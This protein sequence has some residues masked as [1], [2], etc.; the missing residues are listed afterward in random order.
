MKKNDCMTSVIW[1]GLGLFITLYALRFKLGTASEPGSG[2]MPF[3]SG[4]VICFCSVITFLISVVNASG[5]TKKVWE[6]IRI[7]KLL[8]VFIVLLSYGLLM[9]KIGFILCTFGM[10]LLLVRFVDPQSWFT[11]FLTA[12]VSSVAAYLLFETWLQTQLPRGIF[13]F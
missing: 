8:L 1:F 3:V 7:R 12:G 2:L 4:V 13:G 9:E 10:V 5:N 6:N 11:S